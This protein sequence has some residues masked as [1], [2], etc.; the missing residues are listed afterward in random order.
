MA[1]W[2]GTERRS[3]TTPSDLSLL[4]LKLETLHGD[5]A[6]IK[7]SMNELTKAIMKLALI[8]ERI[9]TANAAQ[10]RAFNSISKLEQRVYQLEQKAPLN[11]KTTAWIDRG[12]L[13]IIGASVMF[14]I[15]KIIK[16]HQ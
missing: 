8:E 6:E 15:E 10:E 12:V 7:G 13:F 9:G 2:N 1:D 4:S 11:D 3:S 14:V 16:G 5:V